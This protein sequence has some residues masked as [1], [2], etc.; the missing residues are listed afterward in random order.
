MQAGVF[1]GTLAGAWVLGAP[2]GAWATASLG[3][4]LIAYA[5]WSLIG[6]QPRLSASAERWMGPLTGAITGGVTA[7]T[8][9]FAVPSVPY[10]QALR[11]ERDA[12]IQAM[13][14]SFTVSTIALAIGLYFN[15]RYNGAAM[16]NSALMLLPALLGMQ[17]GQWLRQRLSPALFRRCFLG[18]L[19][20]LGAYMLLMA[21]RST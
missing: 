21:L 5:A 4:A 15:G 11:L 6:A 16:G 3:V 14:L 13:G 1:I 12:L 8:G 7:A 17:L 10:L 20:L 2:A 19:L 18:S 9:V